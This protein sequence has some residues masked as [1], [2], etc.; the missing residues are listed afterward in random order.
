MFVFV[1]PLS[2]LMLDDMSPL[3][4]STVIDISQYRPYRHDGLGIAILR[5]LSTYLSLR[6]TLPTKVQLSVRQQT[7]I[8]A[9]KH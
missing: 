6:I 8:N 9:H 2:P 5:L 1:Q 4:A 3:L 7:C